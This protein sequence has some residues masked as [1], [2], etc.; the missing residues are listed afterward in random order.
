[1]RARLTLSATPLAALALA[2]A[3]AGAALYCLAAGDCSLLTADQRGHRAFE[4]GDFADAASR[5][6]DPSWQ[7]V[8]LYRDGRFEQAAALFAGTD[9]AD[10]ALN[11]GNALVMLGRYEAAVESYQRAL[12][13]RP[14]WTDAEINR[15][16]AAGRAAALA[17]QGGDMTG[18]ALGADAT[19]FEE[20]EPSSSSG[21]EQLEAGQEATD[22]ELRAI[23]LRQVQTRPADFLRAKFARQHAAQGA[24]TE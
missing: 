12:A 19:V 16:I 24:G 17:R 15:D 6:A 3:A 21:E 11:Q 9:T 13:L 8:A 20:G 10:A 1:M 2:L 22:A 23:W 14:G 4:Q 7:A 5:F 18:G